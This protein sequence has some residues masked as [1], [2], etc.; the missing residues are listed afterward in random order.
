LVHC[1]IARQAHAPERMNPVLPPVVGDI[2]MKLLAKNA[3]DRYQ[4]VAGLVADLERCL[5]ELHETGRIE[6][7]EL[8]ASDAA[9]VLRL[10]Q[11]LYGRE[12]DTEQ[13]L[14]AF[15]RVAGGSAEMLLI[16]GYSGIGK[17][18]LANELQR[19]VLERGGYFVSGK[20]DQFKR[21]V[22]YSAIN[23]ALR[24]L[25]RRILCEPET[26]IAEWRE[27]LLKAVGPNGQLMID[28]V[29]ELEYVIGKQQPAPPPSAGRNSFNY[30]MQQFVGA[31]TRFEHPLVLFLDDLQWADAASLKLISILMK[32]LENPCLLL[33]GAYRSNEV[34]ATHPLMMMVQ[35]V[36]RE[37]PVQAI[38]L[39]PLS[40][41]STNEF[42]ADTL[43]TTLPEAAPLADLIHRKT[44]G[45]PFFVMQFLKAIHG[46]GL[47]AFSAGRWRWDMARIRSLAITDNVVDLLTRELHRLS[48]PVRQILTLAACI[49]NRF[50]VSALATV[51]EQ[52]EGEAR[53]QLQYALKA[54]LIAQAERSLLQPET[55]SSQYVFMHDRVQ[56]A[57]YEGIPEEAR[58]AVHL[59]IGRLLLN[60][61]SMAQV[62]EHVFDIVHQ[63]NLGRDLLQAEH[64]R[65]ELARLNLQAA[66][67]ARVSA[68]FDVHREYA[69]LALAL[70]SV[71]VWADKRQFMHE[72][73]M[74]LIA[75]A[76]AR[77]DYAEMEKL[78]RIV[79][80]NSAS[81]QEAIAAKEMLIRCYGA[82]YKP[83]ELMNTGVEMMKLAG[84]RVPRKLGARHVWAARMRLWAA[85]RGRNV[86]D[87]ANLPA[88][89]DPQYLLQ[90]QATMVFLAYGLTYLADSKMVLWAALEMVRKSLRYGVSPLCAYAYAVLGRTYSGQLEQPLQGYRFG[91]VSAALGAKRQ[92]SGAIG[93]F[94]GII[95]HRREHIASSLQPL[96]DTFVKA[97]EMGDRAGAMVALQFSDAIRFQSGGKLEETLTALR[98][99]LGV[100][101]KMAYPALIDVMVP[102]TLMVSEISGQDG[103]DLAEGRSI[104]DYAGSRREAKD[105]WGVFYVRSVQ[106]IGDYYLGRHA[107]ALAHAE[108][109][110][111]LPG[112]Y[113]GTPASGTL[114]FVHSL[115][116]LALCGMG[117][118]GKRQ[119]RAKVAQ[120][121]R[122]FRLWAKH[123]PMNYL[124][125]WQLVE[126]ERMRLAGNTLKAARYYELA[127]GGARDHGYPG[128]EALAH[129]LT[130]RFYIALG[131]GLQARMHFQ[132]AHALY[133]EWGALAKCRELESMYP[134]LLADTLT[135]GSLIRDAMGL[136][137]GPTDQL[138][139]ETFIRASQTLSGE[140]QLDKLLEK[141]M[142][143]MIE[144]AGAEKGL[145]LL[146]RDGVLAIEAI[147]RGERIDVLQS[148]PVESSNE[149]SP[150]VINYVRR[151][152]QSLLLGDAQADA[153]FGSDA[154]IRRNRSRSI[155]CLPLQKRGEL[156]GILDLENNLAAQAFTAEH[157]ELL[158]VLSTQITIS[159]E[160]ATLYDS[161]LNLS[162]NLEKQ[163]EERTRDLVIAKEAAEDANRAKSEFLAV[164]SHEIRTPMNGVLGMM[165]LALADADTPQQRE[166]LETA[167]YSAEALLAILNDILDLSKLESGNLQFETINFDLIK[168]VESVVAL[169]S[170]R[171]QERGLSIHFDNATGLPRYL[172]GDVAR[173]RQ[174]LLNLVSNAIKFTEKGGIT[175]SVEHCGE[176]D[177]GV[178]LC[179]AVADS[180]I[181]IAPEVLGNLF[182]SFYQ[183]DSSISRRFG[184][185]GLGLSICR[186][187]VEAQ[188]GRIGVDS[189]L[190]SGSRFWFELQFA[191]GIAPAALNQ[192]ETKR[193]EAGAGLRILLAEDNEI[194][195]KVAVAL[196]QKAGHEV[197]V[198]N[199]GREAL[200]LLKRDAA[201]DVVLMDMHM[202]EMNGLE[203]TREIRRLEGTACGVPI[204]AL[205]AAGSLSDIQQCQ[206]AGMNH[207][208]VKPFRMDR[209]NAVLK[210]I[211]SGSTAAE[212]LV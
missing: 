184:G 74:E 13:L 65:D 73:Y 23:D 110:M 128:E 207:F 133:R 37:A 191:K 102:W 16:T 100:Y 58:K 47:L 136:S 198:A 169:M 67:K 56:Q 152:R 17:S 45:N 178:S 186:K 182:Q 53:Q 177:Q 149:V 11:H 157:A 109:A 80:N 185:T 64:D 189:T 82:I 147:V 104:E 85:L 103:S 24:E 180:G 126:A 35:E 40:E 9:D 181:G 79:S 101:R 25:V 39:A 48:A 150:A 87:L 176:S 84:V 41:H 94:N 33:I 27:K 46:E 153:R 36:G 26:R 190:G 83:V 115:S 81:P 179:F 204:V 32:G 10:P 8:G 123:A 7:F 159:L 60:S 199:D 196:L 107:A 22:P 192:P 208:L 200:T 69:D 195:Q 5:R 130:F 187:I 205:T 97:M 34:D 70:G 165:Q 20:F 71:P 114:M 134:D 118:A 29:P 31:F 38:E 19:P 154:Y 172:C 188:G 95:R 212:S 63:L 61:M 143:L 122:R 125:K 162:R 62:E 140:I 127:A 30:L 4:T 66:K 156:V 161:L 194:N 132:R 141:L 1:H 52:E 170:S 59:K 15:D 158:Q 6:R 129:E 111:S 120:T 91:K 68:A 174:V 90:L 167:L 72:L 155:L 92:L 193:A 28:V 55:T 131:R 98:R 108:E 209:M 148:L 54:S 18:A 88:A 106:C 86:Q 151:T 206:D 42:I 14:N 75:S 51:S 175:V 78:C 44:L 138:D 203:A 57:A 163:V 135:G 49:G 171:A 43:R 160:N 142:R 124:H 96:L 202:P 145:L 201:F 117:V 99:N 168:T 197:V 144:N 76:F 89:T 146:Q 173:L 105:A 139:V 119:G 164:M 116:Q 93:I 166:R 77:A 210:E 183:A 21:G 3:E 112:F 121:Q 113:Y 211:A 50:D 12:S 137:G 2:V